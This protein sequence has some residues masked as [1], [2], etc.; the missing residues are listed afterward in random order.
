M[1]FRERWTST[2]EACLGN[3]A[4]RVSLGNELA[5]LPDRRACA[6]R[7][8]RCARSEKAR[9]SAA[10]PVPPH[11]VF[12]RRESGGQGIAWVR[13]HSDL[14]FHGEPRQSVRSLHPLLRN[15]ATC[16][17]LGTRIA[18]SHSGLRL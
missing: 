4:Q 18:F 2:Y 15:S 5:A 12:F 17:G 11:R 6:H 3:P 8:S 13:P 16:P 7:S 14:V 1:S 9:L 10:R